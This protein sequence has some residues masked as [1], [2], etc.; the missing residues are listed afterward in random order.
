MSEIFLTGS[1]GF[2][3]SHLLR[4]LIEMDYHVETDMRYLHTKKYDCVIH[5]AAKTDISCEFNPDLIESNI[6][7]TREIFKVNSR[8]IFGSSCSAEF[9]TNPYAYTKRYGE[10]L[11]Q[12]HGNAVAL[13]FFNIYGSGAGR[14]IVKF[15]MDQPNGAKITLRGIDQLRDYIHCDDVVDAI[16]AHINPQPIMIN[17]KALQDAGEKLKY[18]TKQMIDFAMEMNIRWVDTYPPMEVITKSKIIEIGTGIA[19]STMDL[20][21]LYMEL[22]GKKFEISVADPFPSEPPV[23]FAKHKTI[24]HSLDYGLRKTILKIK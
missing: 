11:C 16:I 1:K 24:C 23:M 3:G 13:R 15:L 22:S 5:L 2:V 17:M 21:N 10:H 20:C 8:I 14:G 6:I 4:R 12:L 7:L 9:L 18:T 19:T